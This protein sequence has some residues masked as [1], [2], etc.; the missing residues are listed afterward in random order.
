MEHADINQLFSSRVKRYRERKRKERLLFSSFFALVLGCA[1]WYFLIFSPSPERTIEQLQK[2]VTRHDPALFAEQLDTE[3]IC[4]AL[5]A[6]LTAS[7]ID[8]D[9]SLSES[10]RK[11]CEKFYAV[12]QPQLL[13]GLKKSIHGYIQT[14]AWQPPESGDLLKGRGLAVDYERLLEHSKLRTTEI[15]SFDKPQKQEQLAL[16]NVKVREKTTGIEATLQLNLQQQSN[17]HWRVVSIDGY[18]D[19]L[20]AVLVKQNKAV[21]DYVAATVDTVQQSNGRLDVL[22]SRFKSIT[23]RA[24]GDFSEQSLNSLEALIYDEI[25][26]CLKARQAS[27]DAVPVPGGAEYLS[28]LRRHSTELDI[29]AWTHYLKGLEEQSFAELNTA[30]TLKEQVLETELRISDIITHRTVSQALPQLP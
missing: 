29:A 25:I 16:C 14:G 17:S 24:R 18:R 23:R 2:A 6:D 19:Y 9:L 11:R 21:A 1:A 22:Q 12:I 20:E 8:G 7:L 3:P 10:D 13:D 30:E 26:P 5:T 4:T 15:I 28:E 27:L